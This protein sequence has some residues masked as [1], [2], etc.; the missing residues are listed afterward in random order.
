MKFVSVVQGRPFNIVIEPDPEHEGIFQLTVDGEK[1]STEVVELKPTSI[2]MGINERIGFYEYTR[3]KGR[4][5]EV[6]LGYLSYEVQIKTPQQEQ[7]EQLLA[8]FAKNGAGP[9]AL[10]SV[11]APMPGKILE[12]YVKPGDKVELGN[13]VAVLE[14]M[15]MENEITSTVDGVVKALKVKPGDTVV[16]DQELI[17]FE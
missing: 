5:S 14:A 16:L 11:L 10:K 3:V 6:N 13:V 17:E 7:L 1:I 12:L 15:K 4:L 2:T 9:S 8:K